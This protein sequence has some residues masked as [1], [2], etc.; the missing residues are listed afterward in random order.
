M[1]RNIHTGLPMH[2][3]KSFYTTDRNNESQHLM[4]ICRESQLLGCVCNLGHVGLPRAFVQ[5][6]KNGRK[7]RTKNTKQQQNRV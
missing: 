1:D 7:T 4:H 2:R 3:V 5:M 6:N